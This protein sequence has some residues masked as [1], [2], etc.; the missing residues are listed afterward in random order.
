MDW[1]GA[2][3]PVIQIER[4]VRSGGH[5]SRA[6]EIAAAHQRD[7]LRG[8]AGAFADEREI[9]DRVIAP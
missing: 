1:I 7:A 9:I 6:E 3:H 2:E 5:A 8:V 4:A